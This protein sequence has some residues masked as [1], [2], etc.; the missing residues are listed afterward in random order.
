MRPADAAL[1]VRT[2]QIGNVATPG[3]EG[4][5]RSRL[6]RVLPAV[7][8][9]GALL[10]LYRRL[11]AVGVLAQPGVIELLRPEVRE[12]SLRAA[13]VEEQTDVVIR[14]L[15][16]EGIPFALIKGQARRAAAASFYPYGDARSPS[17]VDVLVQEQDAEA[18]WDALVRRGHR[19]AANGDGPR[20][21][22]LHFHLPPIWDERLVAVEIHF[23]TDRWLPPAEAWRRATAT[24]DQVTWWGHELRIPSAT[25]LL[26]HVAAHAFKGGPGDAFRLRAFLDAAA[27]LSGSRPINWEVIRDRIAAGEVKEQRWRRSS[28]VVP[29]Q[30][31]ARWLGTAARLGG[32]ELPPDLARAGTVSLERLI[33]WRSLVAGLPLPRLR[34]RILMAGLLG[35]TG[36]D[37]LPWRDPGSEH[38][39]GRAVTRGARWSYA[40]WRRLS[41]GS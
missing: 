15:R 12:L 7:R 37:A 4:W 36:L 24:A 30:V 29:D 17:D 34:R 27:V 13:R 1:L 26:W 39:G 10:W 2:L 22:P 25:E 41:G 3:T 23:S 21:H 8:D 32:T 5:T 9:Q 20:S 28:P 19:V 14:A 38:G 33:R 6:E 35:E 18:A 11:D 40:A 31:I 16:E